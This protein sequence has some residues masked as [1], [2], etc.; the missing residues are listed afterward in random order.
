[1]NVRSRFFFGA[2]ETERSTSSNAAG[3]MA[4]SNGRRFREA[5]LL[6]AMTALSQ[7]N[8][9]WELAPEALRGNRKAQHAIPDQ[10][11]FR[12]MFSLEEH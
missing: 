10:Q 6:E 9:C 4:I 2:P 12:N 8:G 1:M 7:L 5:H 3:D 11:Q